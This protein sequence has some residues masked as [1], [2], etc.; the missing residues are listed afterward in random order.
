MNYIFAA[1]PLNS[2]FSDLQGLLFLEEWIT[3]MGI[4]DLTAIAAAT[5]TYIVSVA[6]V[7]Q[8][9]RQLTASRGA[10]SSH[11]PQLSSKE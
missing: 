9:C 6:S 10:Y 2:Y 5:A 3:T 4:D 1:L 11:L 7:A 8:Q